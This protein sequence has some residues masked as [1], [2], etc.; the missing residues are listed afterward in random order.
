MRKNLKKNKDDS[1]KEVYKWL[2]E[3]EDDCEQAGL[4]GLIDTDKDD[5]HEDAQ[6]QCF[7]EWVGELNHNENE[8]V[9]S[10]H[11]DIVATIYLP[12][13]C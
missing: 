10:R 8:Y 7:W 3:G 5:E 11:K 1:G 2:A 13:M 9:P 4:D 12:S 6:K